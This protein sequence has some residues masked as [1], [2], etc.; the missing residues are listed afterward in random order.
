MP[1]PAGQPPAAT[2]EA[3]PAPLLPISTHLEQR[4]DEYYARLQ[5]V[6]ERGEV[7]PWLHFFLGAIADVA[8]DAVA[9]AEQMIDLREGYR[10]AV[11]ASRSRVR[12]VV[13]LMFTNPVLTP[14]LVARRLTMTTQGAANLLRQLEHLGALRPEVRGPGLQG[15]W[16]A[17]A[18]LEVLEM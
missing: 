15:R 8:R 4:R 10:Q 6:R 3:L 13:D 18:V 17:D 2:R 5:G 16:Y 14:R 12:E 9:R 1:R 11:R 7:G